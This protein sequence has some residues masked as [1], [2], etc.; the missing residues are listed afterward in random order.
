MAPRVQ[1]CQDPLTAVLKARSS[2]V[3]EQRSHSVTEMFLA[4]V[5]QFDHYPPYQDEMVGLHH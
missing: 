2:T 1:L 4:L 5:K 3:V